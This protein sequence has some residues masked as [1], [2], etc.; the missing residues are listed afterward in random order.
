MDTQTLIRRVRG[1]TCLRELFCEVVNR[2]W[3]SDGDW[4]A[5]L[6]DPE[7]ADGLWP[8]AQEQW[9]RMDLRERGV[10]RT[11]KL[12]ICTSIM[13]GPICDILELPGGS[14]YAVGAR[15]LRSEMHP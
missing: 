1:S 7:L 14:T 9:A 13:P 12:W 8:L 15:K 10:W 4:W 3:N 2:F 11:G 6:D 5:V